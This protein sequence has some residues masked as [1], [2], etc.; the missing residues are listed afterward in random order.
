MRASIQCP[1]RSQLGFLIQGIILQDRR[2]EHDQWDIQREAHGAPVSMD[3]E[4][5]VDVGGQRGRDKAVQKS[6]ISI[7]SHDRSDIQQA[8][9]YKTGAPYSMAS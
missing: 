1:F 4:N 3:A 7:D 8:Q 2:D 9:T 6:I 5:L